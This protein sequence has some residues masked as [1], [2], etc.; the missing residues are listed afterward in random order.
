VAWLF[1]LL[2]SV[3]CG[4]VQRAIVGAPVTAAPVDVI[5]VV[6]DVAI[7]SPRGALVRAEG[8]R[9]DV[10]HG[11]LFIS[12]ESRVRKFRGRFVVDEH[13]PRR[14]RIVIDFDLT[15][16]ENASR[17][18]TMTLQYEFLEVDA[19]PT[20][21]FEGSFLPNG[22][23]G[24]CHV[25]GTLDLHGIKRPIAFDGRMTKEGGDLHFETTFDL[26]RKQWGIRQHD[27]WDWINKDDFRLHI[28]LHGTPEHV[29]AEE[30]P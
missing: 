3:G 18:V 27:E 21:R 5:D 4:G 11:T 16:F 13:D 1:F 26:D 8:S 17:F 14:G 6:P 7:A 10:G 30:L 20:A 25:T 29:V 24:A 2:A 15:T 12:F 19:H 23:D 9:V 28:D 22:K